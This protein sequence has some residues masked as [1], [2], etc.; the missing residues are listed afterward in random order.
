MKNAVDEY[1]E[2]LENQSNF[3]AADLRTRIKETANNPGGKTR[4]QFD[5][6]IRRLTAAIA[7]DLECAIFG[8]ASFENGYQDFINPSTGGT[9]AVTGGT[10]V[11]LPN[12]VRF[13]HVNGL[14]TDIIEVTC[15]QCPYPT[16]LKYMQTDLFVINNIRYSISDLA[17]IDQFNNKFEFRKIS[18]FGREDRNPISPISFKKPTDDQDLIIDMPVRQIMDKETAIV[19]S[20]TDT[21]TPLEINLSIFVDYFSKWDSSRLK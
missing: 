6:T 12:S 10:N 16:L 4:A 11:A 20:L 15:P 13:T 17:A 18:I 5:I 7:G 9:V 1:I 3:E 19:L 21:A 14:N 8:P 2:M